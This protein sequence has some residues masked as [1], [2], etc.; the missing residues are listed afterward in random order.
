MGPPPYASPLGKASYYGLR[1]ICALVLAFL[2]APILAIMPLSLNSTGFLSYPMPGLSLQWY[3]AVFAPYPWVFAL[4]NSLIVAIASTALATILGTLASL[5]LARSNLPFRSA[6][7]GL[8]IS[9]MVVPIV[10]TG[11][12]VYFFFAELGLTATY[13]G[14]I[15]A[16]TA[17]AAPFV[18]I[19]V[20]A[21][22]QGFDTNLMRA[23]A[24]L[25]A[26]PVTVFFRIVLPIILPGVISGA[27][28]AFATS[29]DEVVVAIFLAGPAQRTLPLQMFY[30][31]RENIS[32]AIVAVATL[33]VF[34]SVLLMISVE[35][36]RRR[37]ERLRGIRT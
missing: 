8:M 30:G 19:T 24:S 14:L 12:G 11:V 16:H 28:F 5:G 29:F 18:V 17:L 33:L 4:E 22:L 32:P 2:I 26:A 20:T 9:P 3:E 35:L 15:L 7:M 13:L 6:I 25:G 21:T 1:V 10:I 23:G 37:G 31:I 27:L 34:L 36:L